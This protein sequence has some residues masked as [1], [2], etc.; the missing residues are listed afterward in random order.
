MD[1]SDRGLFHHPAP[2][3]G[4]SPSSH[5]VLHEERLLRGSVFHWGG[6][7]VSLPTLFPP[8]QAIQAGRR[9]TYPHRSISSFPFPSRHQRPLPGG[10]SVGMLALL[11]LL[12]AFNPFYL[13][14]SFEPC[15]FPP[16]ARSMF[17]ILPLHNSLLP[18][19]QGGRSRA[20]LP[21][22]AGQQQ[23]LHSSCGAGQS[24]QGFPRPT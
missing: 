2:R 3:S 12:M 22:G 5:G 16:S 15:G 18:C 9:V 14:S 6:C 23:S 20:A 19:F 7:F 4:A 17:L 1:V 10:S 8:L 21:M 24:P 13:F 11:P